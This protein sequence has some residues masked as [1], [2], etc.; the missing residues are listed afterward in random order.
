MN[1]EM[2]SEEFD[3]KFPLGSKVTLIDLQ[4]SLEHIE[5]VLTMI[6]KARDE[7]EF[8][9]EVV[10]WFVSTDVKMKMFSQSW[11]TLT[12]S[13]KAVSTIGCS[14]ES[15]MAYILDDKL[16]EYLLDIRDKIKLVNQEMQNKVVD[17][18]TAVPK[19]FKLIGSVLMVV[20]Y[21]QSIVWENICKF[22]GEIIPRSAIYFSEMQKQ[23]EQKI[24]LNSDAE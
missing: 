7:I 21:T 12:R 23:C 13:L 19:F 6:R 17:P 15:E 16:Q 2:L 4:K 24:D 20:Y 1:F 18:T 10:G 22:T 8:S 9:N 14:I 11:D 3:I 5:S